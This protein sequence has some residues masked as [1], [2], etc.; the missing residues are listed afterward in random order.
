MPS[1]KQSRK[2]SKKKS[3]NQKKWM[4]LLI[5]FLGILGLS[6]LVLLFLPN[7]NNASN[8][9]N[10]LYINSKASYEDVLNQLDQKELL[11]SKL[12]F[13]LVAS[14]VN[15]QHHIKPGKYRIENNMTNFQLIKMLRLGQQEQVKLVIN[16]LRTEEDFIQLIAKH[17]EPDADSIRNALHEIDFM[18]SIDVPFGCGIC[19]VIPDSYIFSWNTSAHNVLNRLAHYYHAFWNEHRQ[20]QAKSLG[21]S[22][23]EIMVLASIVEEESNYLPEKGNIASVYINRLKS[24]MKLQ[25]DPTAKYAFGDF[26]IKRVTSAITALPSP[27]NTYHT[28]GLPP[29]PICTPSKNTIDAVL[30]APKTNFFYFCAKEDFS[31]QHR[32]AANYVEHMKNAALYQQA[33]NKRNIH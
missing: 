4:L 26:S 8:E 29:T 11:S 16:K 28:I 10:Y 21:F 7:V 12:C 19:T 33:L 14:I 3:K 23:N 22:E 27:Y 5:A 25:A 18:K 6:G 15:Y 24:G 17:L 31:G 2:S 30:N 20:N 32:F 1:R 9:Y 13:K